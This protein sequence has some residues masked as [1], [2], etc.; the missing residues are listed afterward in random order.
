MKNA[1]A[2]VLALAA[3]ALAGG[4]GREEPARP[5]DAGSKVGE[6]ARQM[7]EAA[8]AGDLG[9]VGEAAKKM[10]SALTDAVQVEPVDFRTLRD[11]LP[12]KFAGM[13]RAASEGSRTKVMGVA[14]SK[15]NAKY[16]DGKGGTATLEISDAGT[17]TGIAA[18]AV[19]WIHVEIDKEGDGGY[20]RTT[21]IDGRRAYERFDKATR[22]GKL[23]VVAAGRFLVSA[24]TTGIDMKAFREA[25]SKLDL[26]KLEALKAA[27]GPSAAPGK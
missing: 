4:C 15:A 18:L 22:T 23:D 16:A 3:A 12:E 27:G 9:Q 21:T 5:A 10:G 11:L 20:E 6:A 25:V 2:A 8:K 13:K 24:E 19:A 17:L 14:V 26:A 7:T 1:M